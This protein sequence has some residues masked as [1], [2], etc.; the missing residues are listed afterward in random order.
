M[1]NYYLQWKRSLDNEKKFWI[2]WIS[3]K[4]LEWKDDFEQRIDPFFQADKI[5]TGLI[6]KNVIRPK[7]LDVGAG[8]ITSFPKILH[9]GRIVEIVPIDILADDYNAALAEAN[10]IPVIATLPCLAEVLTNSFKHES[11]DFVYARNTLDHT[12]NPFLV[13]EEMLSVAKK[14]SSIFL[15][16]RKNL[17][18]M[19]NYLGSAIWNISSENNQMIIWNQ[20]RRINV[21]AELSAYAETH[22]IEGETWIDILM[23]KKD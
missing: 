21:S 9:D 11:F 3:S 17:A 18:A 4:G 6:T 16:H 20:N 13:L 14:G 12:H 22:V 7:V 15:A 8:P 23:K 5:L 10:I 2:N 1:D 19:E